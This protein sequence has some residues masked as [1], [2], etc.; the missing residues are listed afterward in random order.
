LLAWPPDAFALTNVLLD[1]SKAFRCAWQRPPPWS[2]R[3]IDRLYAASARPTAGRSNGPRLAPPPLTP[4]IMYLGTVRVGPRRGLRARTE[5]RLAVTGRWACT[6][7]P[8]AVPLCG[9]TSP[10][11]DNPHGPGHRL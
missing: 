5:S 3:V 11:R 10:R 4:Q 2:R 8:T 9:V 1:G 6:V 7:P